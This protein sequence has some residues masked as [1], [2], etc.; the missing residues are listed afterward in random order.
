MVDELSLGKKFLTRNVVMRFFIGCVYLG[1]QI[2]VDVD[3]DVIEFK[4]MFGWREMGGRGWGKGSEH[5]LSG[6]KSCMS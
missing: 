1:L 6:L 3:V 5:S 4:P 2:M